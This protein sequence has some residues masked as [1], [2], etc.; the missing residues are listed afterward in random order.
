MTMHEKKARTDATGGRKG[1]IGGI[2]VS[3]QAVTLGSE[4]EEETR[5]FA[6]HKRR[7]L[8][9]QTPVFIVVS[10]TLVDA[11]PTLIDAS[12]IFVAA[13]PI[14]VAASLKSKGHK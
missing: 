11:S 12:P 4:G 8:W 1:T 7:K 5:D 9:T 14:L 3:I 6:I 13:F 2:T 10:A